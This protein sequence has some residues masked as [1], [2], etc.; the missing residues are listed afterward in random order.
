MKT[1]RQFRVFLVLSGLLALASIGWGWVR[2]SGQAPERA[3]WTTLR[4]TLASQGSRID[5][6]KQTLARKDA[7]LE[8]A[9]RELSASGERLRRWERVAVDGRLPTSQHRQY[10]RDLDRYN[11]AVEDHNARVAEMQAT[12]AGYSAL[13]DSHNVV[14]DSA[15]TLQRRAVQ[16]GIELPSGPEF[17]SDPDP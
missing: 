12:Y 11:E 14:V 1:S 8:R 6:L 9:K 4:A 2:W 10:L 13:V 7:E 15:N 5:S 17:E 3:A 16:E